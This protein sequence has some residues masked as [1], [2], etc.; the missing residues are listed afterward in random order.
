MRELAP[1]RL[2]YDFP[3]LLSQCWRTSSNISPMLKWKF[4]DT[5]PVVKTFA[6]AT[7]CAKLQCLAQRCGC[8]CGQAHRALSDCL[9]LRR[10]CLHLAQ[11]SGITLAELLGP[12]VVELDIERCLHS[13]ALAS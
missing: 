3:L 12:F 7:D 1:N 13:F 11:A 10:V 2:R 8:T 6:G 5:I 4:V 9:V